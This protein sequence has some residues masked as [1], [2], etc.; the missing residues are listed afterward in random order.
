[1]TIRLALRRFTDR[2]LT[3][4]GASQSTRE[5]TATWYSVLLIPV[6]SFDLYQ[7]LLPLAR[8]ASSTGIGL[9][10]GQNAQPY[11]NSLNWWAVG[12]GALVTAGIVAGIVFSAHRRGLG[13]RREQQ[14]RRVHKSETGDPGGIFPTA[15]ELIPLYDDTSRGATYGILRQLQRVANTARARLDD[16]YF[17]QPGLY[18]KLRRDQG[19]PINPRII[20]GQFDQWRGELFSGEGAVCLSEEEYK[21]VRPM[22]AQLSELE[23]RLRQLKELP[24]EITESID[25]NP[26]FRSHWE[27]HRYLDFPD[28]PW[29][30]D[31]RTLIPDKRWLDSSASYDGQGD[32]KYGWPYGQTLPIGYM[33][34]ALEEA[35]SHMEN[36]AARHRNAIAN[37]EGETA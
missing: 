22:E 31:P 36:L 27:S 30:Q 24:A 13:A 10:Y 15:T 32:N 26:A 9:D 33:L 4:S 2:R 25:G 34:A 1:M 35:I 8:A 7:L 21:P 16:T 18:P 20:A 17:Y 3:P 11:L 23:H 37:P 28:P 29:Y 5:A 19:S 6:L 12:S 14:A